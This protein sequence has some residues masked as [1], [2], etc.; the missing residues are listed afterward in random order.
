MST[1]SMPPPVDWAISKRV[2]KITTPTPSL[3]SDSPTILVSS[4]F[5]APACLR[6]PS[7]AMGSVGEMTAPKSRQ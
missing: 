7:T 6:M 5:G 2:R 1:G 3:K 4:F